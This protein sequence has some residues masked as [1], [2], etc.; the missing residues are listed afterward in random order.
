MLIIRS[1]LHGA[2]G[3]AVSERRAHWRICGKQTY[4]GAKFVFET[5]LCRVTQY[6]VLFG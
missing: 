2:I 1:S 5:N 6:I 3:L 4:F